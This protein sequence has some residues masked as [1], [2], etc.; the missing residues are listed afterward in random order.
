MDGMMRYAVWA[1]KDHRPDEEL[2]LV[3]FLHGGGDHPGSFDQHRIS[4]LLDQAL[5]AGE[6]PRVVI[7]LPDGG[8]GFWENWSDGSRR[9]RD[10]VTDDLMAVIR[11]RFHTLPCPQ[12]CH[13]MGVSMGGHGT[14]RFALTRPDLF[15]SAS[16]LSA[17]V[18]D[19]ES[20]LD[21]MGNFWLRLMVPVRNIWPDIRDKAALR[22]RDVFHRLRRDADRN[23][24]RFAFAW[25]SRDR[26]GIVSTNRK[27]IEHLR[28]KGIKHRSIEFDG[29]HNWVS[30]G[31][32]ITQLLREQVG[33]SPL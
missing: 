27:L 15:R 4:T 9:Y 10:W 29:G 28:D 24:V 1:P 21:F 17:P 13:V 30:W 7:V 3:V 26:R 18:F 8:T 2:P 16:A 6:I 19:S 25:A 22:K 33:E 23:G 31:P 11:K 20:A 5:A 14:L 32:I 12:G